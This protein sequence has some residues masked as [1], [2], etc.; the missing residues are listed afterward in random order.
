MCRCHKKIKTTRFQNVVLPGTVHA[1]PFKIIFT[2]FTRSNILAV[3]YLQYPEMINI[4]A[5]YQPVLKLS[6]SA[7]PPPPRKAEYLFRV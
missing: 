5:P 2:T 6:S 4:I 1:T 3:F 7:K